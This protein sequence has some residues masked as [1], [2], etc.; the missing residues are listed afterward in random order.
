MNNF[1]WFL[2]GFATATALAI[3]WFHFDLKPRL[4]ALKQLAADK[5]SGK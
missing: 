2:L 4:D 5:L 3:W 1:H